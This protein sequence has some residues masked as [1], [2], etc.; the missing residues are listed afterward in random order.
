[1]SHVITNIFHGRFRLATKCF[2]DQRNNP[3]L[4]YKYCSC[5]ALLYRGERWKSVVYSLCQLWASHCSK[6]TANISFEGSKFQFS[7]LHTNLYVDWI[8]S[9]DSTKKRDVNIFVGLKRILFTHRRSCVKTLCNEKEWILCYVL[10][11]LS[12]LEFGFVF[13]FLTAFSFL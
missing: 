2:I 12:I 9:C 1:M 13:M 7:E 8:S 3:H 11:I 5:R 6:T 10:V 4:R